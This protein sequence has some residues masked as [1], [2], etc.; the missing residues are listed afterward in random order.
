MA[1]ICLRMHLDLYI[2]RELDLIVYLCAQCKQ[3][4]SSFKNYDLGV[5]MQNLVGMFQLYTLSHY[6]WHQQRDT[7]AV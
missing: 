3:H 1:D 2:R 5:D 6:V 4:V 7:V